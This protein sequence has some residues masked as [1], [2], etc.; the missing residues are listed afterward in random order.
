MA[1][2]NPEKTKKNILIAAVE[3]FAENGFGGARVDAIA[4]SS[5]SNKRMIYHYF[6]NKEG[7][8]LAVLEH[9]Y[10]D[11]R[12]HENELNLNE[13]E[14]VEA[15]KLLVDYTFDYFIR[16]P[17]FISLLND[18]NLYKAE[19]LKQSEKIKNMHSS[20]LTELTQLLERGVES[21]DFIEG[22]DP[23]QLYISIAA[24]G[25]FYLSNAHTLSVIFGK[26]LLARSEIET[27]RCHISN[28]ILGY[29]LKK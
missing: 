27:R 5:G 18:E 26:K 25:Y 28:V 22:V 19:H 10:A 24:E 8:Y 3:E 29:L 14:P 4:E 23:A 12:S 13:L 1:K 9:V 2:R 17:H 16:N 6:G 21:G 7:L 15:I 20:L 11:I